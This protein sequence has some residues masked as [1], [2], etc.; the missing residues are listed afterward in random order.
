MLQLNS[1]SKSKAALM[2]LV[3]LCMP[4]AAALAAGDELVAPI[5]TREDRADR[6]AGAI[7]AWLSE[8]FDLPAK[9]EQPRIE[10]VSG[11][12]LAALRFGSVPLDRRREVVAVYHDAKRTIFLARDW[13]GRT[14]AEE[15]V[16]VHEMVHHLQNLDGKI[17]ACAEAREYM[18]YEAQDRWLKRSGRSL[19]SEFGIDAM[20]L[21]VSTVCM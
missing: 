4:P 11:E 19:Q 1:P 17:F 8:N 20:T 14:P 12:R 10:F 5:S 3:A 9:W 6:L 7:A 21:K 2:L 16:L 13:T 15:S 18:A